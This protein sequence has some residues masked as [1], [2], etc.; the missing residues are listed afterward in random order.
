LE[1]LNLSKEHLEGTRIGAVVNDVRKKVAESMPSFSSAC[2][3]LIKQWRKQT[4]TYTRSTSSCGGSNGVTPSMMANSPA[5][6]RLVTPQTPHR[7]SDGSIT[8]SQVSSPRVP[9]NLTPAPTVNGIHG[10]TNDL[11]AQAIEKVQLQNGTDPIKLAVKRKTETNISPTDAPSAFKRSKSAL[12]QQQVPSP[13]LSLSA[14]RQNAQSTTELVAQLSENLPSHLIPS[15]DVHKSNSISPVVE[16][17]V[18]ISHQTIH[19]E[20]TVKR[21]YTKRAS[22]FFKDGGEPSTSIDEEPEISKPKNGKKQQPKIATIESTDKKVD[23]FA[24]IPS[25]DDLRKRAEEKINAAASHNNRSS[26][27]V[28]VNNHD[29][30]CFPFVDVGIPDVNEFSYP[31]G[32]CPKTE[33]PYPRLVQSAIKGISI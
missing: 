9:G 28:N 5:L 33:L 1:K 18:N 32:K 25:L 27:V 3:S 7:L 31:D 22:R 17:K 16:N 2:R 6:R 23:W 8:K 4:E 10:S 20:K 29:V 30:I 14:V 12:I 26:Y 15:L 13:L 11:V 24:S 19:E 21:K